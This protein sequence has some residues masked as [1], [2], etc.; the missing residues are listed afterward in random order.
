MRPYRPGD[1][2]KDLH[3]R[4]WA[5]TG[6]PFVREYQEEF[7]AHVAVWVDTACGDFLGASG[8]KAERLAEARLEGGL[9]LAAGILARLLSGE[10]LVDLFVAA[11]AAAEGD[12]GSDAPLALGHG[13][14]TLDAALDV[15]AAV[16]PQ[17]AFEVRRA[18]ASI[19]PHVGELSAL[20]AIVPTW[21]EPRRALIAELTSLGLAC[22]VFVLDPSC[23]ASGD[24]QRI[25][26]LDPAAI[27]RG[28]PVT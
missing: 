28:D 9:S 7:F 27:L 18:R 6:I 2:V 21:D 23:P 11:G 8:P 20:I 24:G 1:P 14:G 25:H 12:T 15:L 26:V 17:P 13:R 16:Q 22:R 10:A 5:R 19:E 4:T 3:A